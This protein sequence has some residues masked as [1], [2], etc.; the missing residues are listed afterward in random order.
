MPASGDDT[1]PGSSFR[2]CSARMPLVPARE[3]LSSRGQ[4]LVPVYRCALGVL[5]ELLPGRAARGLLPGG[6]ERID[7]EAERLLPVPVVDAG[8][9]RRRDVPKQRAKLDGGV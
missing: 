9:R 1:G 6:I 8:L 4:R 3:V 2:R 5:E 7:E